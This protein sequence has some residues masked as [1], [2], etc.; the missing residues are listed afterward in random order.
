MPLSRPSD[1]NRGR[2]LT[3]PVLRPVIVDQPEHRLLLGVERLRFDSRTKRDYDS[4]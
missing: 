3:K 2:K 4:E 1:R